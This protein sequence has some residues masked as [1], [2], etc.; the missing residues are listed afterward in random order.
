MYPKD[1]R[2]LLLDYSMPKC[3]FIL[4]YLLIY[5][6]NISYLAVPTKLILSLYATCSYLLLIND[7]DKPKSIK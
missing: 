7:F 4:A 5:K 3:A 1:S 2:S 6:I